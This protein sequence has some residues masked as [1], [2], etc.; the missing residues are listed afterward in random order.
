M[1]GAKAETLVE[2]FYLL[3]DKLQVLKRQLN[4]PA[5]DRVELSTGAQRMA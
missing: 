5:V 1:V 2:L 4:Q 3:L